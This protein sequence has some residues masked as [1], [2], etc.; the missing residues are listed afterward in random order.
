MKNTEEKILKQY[1][2]NGYKACSTIE[3]LHSVLGEEACKQELRLEE[4]QQKWDFMKF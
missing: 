2:E 3:Y 4:I 1:N